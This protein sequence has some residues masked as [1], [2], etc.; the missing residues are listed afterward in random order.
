MM[1]KL[2]IPCDPA[3]RPGNLGALLDLCGSQILI[4]TCR[5]VRCRH[6]ALVGM[7]MRDAK[8][9]GVRLGRLGSGAA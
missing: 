5:R 9:H 7:A 8:G 1:S 2:P 6:R 4:V 3:F